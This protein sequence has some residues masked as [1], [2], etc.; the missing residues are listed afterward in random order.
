MKTNPVLGTD[1][2]AVILGGSQSGKS[3]LAN[4]AYAKSSKIG[5]FWN[6]DGE[7]FVKGWRVKGLDKLNAG[8]RQ[9]KHKFSYEM[10]FLSLDE[11]QRFDELAHWILTT[12][13]R[14][15]GAKFFVVIDES[16]ELAPE[17]SKNTPV[18]L[19][20]KRGLKRNVQVVSTTQ[21]P[22]T[23]ANSAARQ[24]DRYYWVGEMSPTSAK[25][26]RE[27]WNLSNV[28]QLMGMSEYQY[29]AIDRSGNIVDSG[30]GIRCKR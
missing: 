8:L 26:L 13:E 11:S 15:Q 29:K 2:N 27:R 18:H 28:D 30:D 23:F 17:G 6:P 16:H 4:E 1:K 21:D 14:K 9:G 7:S 12:A 5:I 22:A 3:V 24:A 25:Y 10:P 19:L 20:Y